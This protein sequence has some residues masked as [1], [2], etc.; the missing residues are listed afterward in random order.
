MSENEFGFATVGIGSPD[1]RQIPIKD[2]VRTHWLDGRTASISGLENGSFVLAVHNPPESGL[3]PCAA[4]WLSRESFLAL[5]A[6][7]PVY[8][9]AKEIDVEAELGDLIEG[10]CVSYDISK[11][12]KDIV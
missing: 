10:Q 9:G 6:T 11:N 5:S 7:I 8:L 2:F 3:N 12:L 1:E 4:I